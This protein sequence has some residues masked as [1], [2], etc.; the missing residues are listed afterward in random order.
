MMGEG[1]G[2]GVMME[3]VE[4]RETMGSEN[5]Q[6]KGDIDEQDEVIG[7]EIVGEKRKR[8]LWR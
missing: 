8:R 2:S 4:E 3:V 7:G 6:C 5:E 1:G